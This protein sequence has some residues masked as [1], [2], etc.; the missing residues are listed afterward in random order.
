MKDARKTKEDFGEL[1]R[2]ELI[3]ELGEL[4]Q[5]VAELEA[6]EAGRERAE[7]EIRRRTAQLEALRQVGLGL[8]A[9]LDLDSLLH[10]IASQA[11]ELLGG[12]AGGLDLYRPDQDVLK[13]T[14]SIGFDPVPS[15]IVLRRGEGLSGRVWETGEPL[16]LHDYHHWEGRAAGF[17]DYPFTASVGVPVRWG[18]EFLGVL[19]VM[20]EPPRTFS[21]PDAEL[22]SLFATQA[23]I[24][25]RNARLYEETHSRAERLAVVNHISRAVGAIVNLDDLMET[26]YQEVSSIFQAAA[27]FIALYD[28]GANELDFR[29]RLDEGI[30][31][32]REQRPLGIGF[33]AFVVSEKKPFLVRD[34]EK[35]RDQLPEASLWG[36][37]KAPSSWL[38]VPMLIGE[39]LIGVICVQ[40]YRP[41]VYGEEEELLLSTIAD[42][43]AVA[44][45]Q[46]RLYE[47]ERDQRALAE[48][49]EEAVAA[50][51]ATLDFDQ[52]LDC[53][54]EQVSRV[55][56]N[57][58][59]N[60]MLIEG[61][62]VRAVR[63]RGYE[64]LDADDLF[65]TLVL[66]FSEL[67][68]FQQMAESG[69][70][71]VIPD[72]ATY[73]GWVQVH[74]WLRSYAAAPI[75]VH[76]EVIGFLS[77][78]SAT[79]GFFTQDH[80]EAL[81]AF[82]DHAA[83]AIEN[84]H[85]YEAAQQEI[86]ERKQAEEALR[87]SE[88]RFQQVAD[89]AQE[90]IWEVDAYGLYTYASPIVE[91]MLGYKPE[92]VVGRKHFYDLLHPEDREELKKAAFEVFAQ[93]RSFRE[94]INRN[95]H[96][97]SETVWLSTSGVPM[98]D[99][100]GNLLGYRGSD[101]D[102]TERKQAEEEI[103]RRQLQLSVLNLMG[104]ALAE[105]FEL[106]RIYRIAYE[107]V[108]QLV[109]CPCFGVSL[110]DPPTRTLRAE[111]MLDDGELIDAARF[112]PLV[113]D[114]EPTQGRVRAIATRQPEIITN[115]PAVLEKATDRGVRVGVSEDE[116]VIGAAMYVPMIARGQ[117]MGLLEVQSYRLEAYGAEHA[118]L[119]GPVANQIGLSIQNA[120]LYEEARRELA[121]RKRAEEEL[122]HTLAKLR[123]ALG[124][125]I[126]TVALTV[127]TRDPYTA[128][129]QRRVSNLARAIANEMGLS[130]EQTDGIRMAGLIHDLGKI[131]IPTEI[132][133]TPSRLNDLQ[134]GMI[135]THPQVGYDILKTID[136]PWP[137]AEIVLQHHERMDG[138]GYPQGL[139]GEGIM[140]EARVLAVAD[141]VEAMA[142]HRPYRPPHGLDKALEEISQNRG[143]LYDPEVVDACL[144]LFTEKGFELE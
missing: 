131:A 134:W 38:G 26:V 80:A 111:F 79:R 16:I 21:P 28:E 63:W 41:Y 42:Q 75:I 101:I 107:H 102:I 52:V 19:E 47:A 22:L 23:A 74:E 108:A 84:A 70:P 129:H 35:E 78:D 128:G 143:I 122:Q 73:P 120:Q 142:S 117:V 123:E 58:A 43:V 135:Q 32:P 110:Y 5:R 4:R 36:T 103:G 105:T 69:E 48:A 104:R 144:K 18:E 93:K 9:E 133:I 109:D 95:V 30:R 10:S 45:E 112:P 31:E 85:L 96:R 92:E 88:G 39:R 24:A 8:T 97:D 77:V 49:L 138:S 124:G 136:F 121:E 62:Q 3:N 59:A 94:F 139:S 60:I 2:T 87:E 55:V 12:I 83:A 125:I 91:K 86:A 65:S 44:I 76:G 119:L 61:D 6:L 29:L 132:L 17:E 82:A 99:E 141:V 115:Y 71:M 25:I 116:H 34:F 27:F 33:T 56:P 40:D 20:A 72:V 54:L 11:I 113:M 127:E 13:W 64:R 98:L 140:L 90:W 46:A 137:L 68:G 126:R 81:R 50:L 130:E 1:S 118:A 53:I 7:E 14:A 100:K 37:M 57:D 67:R 66:D 15:E 114:M 89:N 51:T 106:A